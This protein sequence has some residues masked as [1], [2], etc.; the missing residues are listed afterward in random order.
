MTQGTT[1][2]SHLEASSTPEWTED[3]LG[4]GYQCTT[5]DLGSDPEH[6]AD[7][8]TT[9]VRYR[10]TAD[11]EKFTS[12]P[13]LLL[14]SGMTDYFFHTE[15]A[16]YFHEQGY[17]V[18]AIDLR[19]CGRSHRQGHTWHY[20]TDLSH[21]FADLNAAVDVITGPHPSLTPVAHSTGGL[22]A[23][24]WLDS[25]RRLDPARHQHIDCLVLNS[26]WLDLMFPRLL[27]TVATPGIKLL[28]R[29]A[30]HMALP[31]DNLG[32]YGSSIH[33]STHGEWN[34]DTTFKPIAGHRKHFGWL[35][36]I[37]AGQ[38]AIHS[39]RVD[40]GVDVLTLCSSRSW[41]CRDYSAA[42]D[43][44]DV[45][46]DVTQIHQWAPHVHSNPSRVNIRPIEGARH[47]VF[48]SLA[49]ARHN[50]YETMSS[51]LNRHRRP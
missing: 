4:P 42:T 28:G 20:S 51:W 13:A 22:I 2:H 21:Y 5:I 33:A 43:T 45:V 39:D 18:Y 32:I 50:A 29:F 26:P 16:E 8:V 23:T 48:L 41:R 15:F 12:R 9:L 31:S 1:E 10:P 6:E 14:V 17:A 7:V 25:L 3:I 27:V 30:P 34:F 37:I 24:L 11:A 36:A 47:D 38:R 44:A 19:K 40:V 46:L 49:Y 35:K